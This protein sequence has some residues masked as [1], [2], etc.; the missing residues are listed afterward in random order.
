[1]AFVFRSHGAGLRVEG[2]PGPGK[3]LC[4]Q[5]AYQCVNRGKEAAL[6]TAPF[7]QSSPRKIWQENVIPGPGAYQTE[8]QKNNCKAIIKNCGKSYAIIEAPIESSNFKSA[9]KRFQL[10]EEANP[11]PGQ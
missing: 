5:G 11:G 2:T 1:M 4:D 7:N 3:E 8:T 6:A 9:S 10:S